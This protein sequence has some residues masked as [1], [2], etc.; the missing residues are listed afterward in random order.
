[1]GI[2]LSRPIGI[3]AIFLS[4]FSGSAL[5]VN[6][7]DASSPEYVIQSR[8]QILYV[9]N[10]G[11]NTI[12]ICQRN[13]Y[14]GSILD[15]CII[16]SAND[17]LSQPQEIV[18]NKERTRA[19]ISNLGAVKDLAPGSVT[20]CPV[21]RNGMFI[22]ENCVVMSGNGSFEQPMG[23]SLGNCDNFL[24]VA[25][26]LD[27]TPSS[28]SSCPIRP[29]G[30]FADCA[31]QYHCGPLGSN[32]L[33]VDP[34]GKFIYITNY[35]SN[36]DHSSPNEGPGAI[37]ICPLDG[38]GTI[39]IERCVQSEAGNSVNGPF[40]IK[41]SPLFTFAIIASKGQADISSS[42]SVC[43][44]DQFTGLLSSECTS[45]LNENNLSN[46][47]SLAFDPIGRFV[48]ITDTDNNSVTVCS[49]GKFG[50][51]SSCRSYVGNGFNQPT[52][53]FIYE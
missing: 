49:A 53:I 2:F 40:A 25:N 3:L 18:L 50:S 19:Y 38:C 26:G 13:Q 14:D 45:I 42:I 22:E 21:D 17:L 44:V 35:Y 12:S 27:S 23:L 10:S 32:G 36:F 28:V 37:T 24:Y 15:N 29:D 47:H 16:S 39:E 1:M 5:T 31:R 34:L 7:K 33:N 51:I 52:G 41:I 4:V 8:N 6:I 48:Y 20:M 11:N 30:T 9:V 46:P 43:P